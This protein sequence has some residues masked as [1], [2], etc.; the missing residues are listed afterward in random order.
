MTADAYTS[1]DDDD[2]APSAAVIEKQA[3]DQVGFSDEDEIGEF[4]RS[5]VNGGV[6]T[7]HGA[8]QKSAT[9]APA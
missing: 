3:Q 6:K 5:D 9:A 8:E 4:D 2:D 7:G 1:L